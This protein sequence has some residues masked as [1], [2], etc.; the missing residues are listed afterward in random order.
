[1]MRAN[2]D[3]LMIVS[4]LCPAMRW[5]AFAARSVLIGR[6]GNVLRLYRMPVLLQ[7]DEFRAELFVAQLN[8]VKSHRLA[9]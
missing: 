7:L 6:E 2:M 5:S 3:D 9:Q 4:C 8:R 1:M